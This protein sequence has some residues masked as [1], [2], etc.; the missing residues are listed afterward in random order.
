VSPQNQDSIDWSDSEIVI[1]LRPK[2]EDKVYEVKTRG[3]FSLKNPQSSEPDFGQFGSAIYSYGPWKWIGQ[4]TMTHQ[5]T[6][7]TTE[8]PPASAGVSTHLQLVEMGPAAP[9]PPSKLTATNCTFKITSPQ[10]KPKPQPLKV[11]Q[12]LKKDFNLVGQDIFEPPKYYYSTPPSLGD[13]VLFN[14]PQDLTVTWTTEK[15]SEEVIETLYGSK[16][17]GVS[18]T[19]GVLDEVATFQEKLV[20][21]PLEP[22]GDPYCACLVQVPGKPPAALHV[23]DTVVCALMNPESCSICSPEA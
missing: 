17:Q 23:H 3:T 9:E 16:L 15:L 22:C 8:I 10:P 4:L 19:A 13:Q 21:A 12:A 6:I 2:G 18:V 7:K 14:S 20:P 11:F 1:L 5:F